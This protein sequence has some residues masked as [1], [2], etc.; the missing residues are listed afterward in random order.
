MR[1][2]NRQQVLAENRDLAESQHPRR[3]VVPVSAGGGGTTTATR[4]T[5]PLPTTAIQGAASAAGPSPGRSAYRRPDARPLTRA[6]VEV[7]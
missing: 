5:Y 3:D 1:S 2:C 4:P 7:E 6:V